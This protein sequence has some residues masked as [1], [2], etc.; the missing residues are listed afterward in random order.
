MNLED[1]K[2]HFVEVS[3]IEIKLHETI[4]DENIFVYLFDETSCY[5]YNINDIFNNNQFKHRFLYDTTI[6]YTVHKT[7]VLKLSRYYNHTILF[8]F[9]S[10]N[11]P[12]IN[13]PQFQDELKYF[14]NYTKTYFI[15]KLE[16]LNDKYY[17]VYYGNKNILKNILLDKRDYI[18]TL[19]INILYNNVI[20]KNNNECIDALNAILNT[21]PY[22]TNND[23]NLSFNFLK[24]TI[25]LYNY[26]IEDIKW[27]NYIQ[28]KIDNNQN[29]IS[30]TYDIFN[31]II[32]DENEY[33]L[34]NS[35][36]IPGIHTKNTSKSICIKYYG[37]NII[38][39]VGLGKTL[40]ILSYIIL[41]SK[42]TF[43]HY[44]EFDN[45]KCN[46]FYKRGKHKTSNCIK[47]KLHEDSL[48]C[49]EHINTLFIDKRVIK[50]KNLEQFNIK[51]YIIKL[52]ANNYYFKTH[53]NLIICPNQ[54]CDQWVRE[55]YDKFKQTNEYA[56]RVLLV[57]T[58][59]QYKN[60]T[61]ADI[62]FADIIIIS[63][64][65]LLNIHYYKKCMH[66]V[67]N[68]NKNILDLLNESLKESNSVNEKFLL[69]HQDDLNIFHNFYY[70]AIY[71]DENHEILNMPK[72]DM[73][74]NMIKLFKSKYKWNITATPFVNGI[75][76]FLNSMNF[77]CEYNMINDLIN[78]N[79]TVVENLNVLFRRNTRQSIKNEFNGTIITDK[80]RL[81]E[82]TEQERTIYDAH[83]HNNTKTNRD[84]LIKLCCDTSIDIETRN[85][86]KNCKTFDEIQNVIL[87]NTK[88]KLSVLLNKIQHYEMHV[89]FLSNIVNRGFIIDEKDEDDQ[90]YESIQHVKADIS[91]LKR[92]ITNDNKEYESMN[93]TYVYLKNAIDNIKNIETCPICLDDIKN[94]QIAITTCGHKFCNNCIYEYID[95]LNNRN[96]IIK[97]PTCNK[98]ISIS[99]I[100]L[101]K[102][103]LE[104][105]KTLHNENLYQLVQRVKSTK[106]GNII[107]YIKTEMKKDDKCIIFSQWDSM[108]TKIGKLLEN[109]QLNVSYCSGTV[110]KRKNAI[111]NFQENP[112][113]NII[114]LSSQH[115]ASGINLT[116]ANKIIFIEPIYGD[117]E[118]RTNIE[119]Q[120]IGRVDR[121]GQKRPIEIIRFIIQDTIEQDIINENNSNT[122]NK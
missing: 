84:F 58:Y 34:Y 100:Y 87:T 11:H 26:Q 51:D 83:I 98:E 64:N 76:S 38:S 110:Y 4:S 14:K 94:D 13:V 24:D 68:K 85:L 78:L 1:I 101:L 33:L 41:N 39:E 81:L 75:K 111:K 9:L 103:S 20:D 10:W 36:L 28:D 82:F 104:I 25:T 67:H 79:K 116:V 6:K 66:I 29:N 30:L 74:N 45:A 119:N 49:K 88:K 62:L 122:E 2:N 12:N 5:I 3:R 23:D 53:A 117:K 16:K 96:S 102:D 86:V 97:C 112:N 40:I 43:N 109:E 92:K 72:S 108:L 42:N 55:Y 71:L 80:T 37:G 61:F 118:Y 93:R 106:I 105:N 120:A 35:T 77:V 17:M 114:C 47:D 95:E 15:V 18:T 121:L 57:V 32:L 60:V 56:K 65:F 21:I 90:I 89:N 63:Y 7:K 50:L 113:A 48:Y 115:C 27:M 107:Y 70:N 19:F 73:L 69:K 31:N 54:L 99:N 44:I 46:Y 59:D 8:P 52:N 91:I 22:N